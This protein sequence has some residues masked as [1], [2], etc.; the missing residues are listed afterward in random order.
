M[1]I[2]SMRKYKIETAIYLP[3]T[4]SLHC[5]FS[6]LT[7]RCA[8]P[9]SQ[10]SMVS[11]WIWLS[12][13]EGQHFVFDDISV[14]PRSSATVCGV[15]CFSLS[16]RDVELFLAERGVVPPTKAIDTG[17]RCLARLRRRL[18]RRL[19][20]TLSASSGQGTGRFVPV[21]GVVDVG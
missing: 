8:W 16:L 11:S 3:T 20:T 17:V 1:G 14:M 7:L 13:R 18:R 15:S 4:S 5:G 10:R 21:D 12:S 19:S 6:C 2:S 9:I